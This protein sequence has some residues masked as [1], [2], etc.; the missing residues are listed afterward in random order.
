MTGV[1]IGVMTTIAMIGATITATV[2]MTIV[3]SVNRMTLGG[4]RAT[5]DQLTTLSTPS[6]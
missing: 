3:I 6:S 5:T 4:S 2:A 1:M